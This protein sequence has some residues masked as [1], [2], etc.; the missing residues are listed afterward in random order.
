MIYLAWSGVNS[1][2][3]PELNSDRNL[4]TQQFLQTNLQRLERELEIVKKDKNEVTVQSLLQRSSEVITVQTIVVNEKLPAEM[5]ATKNH[6]KALNAVKQYPYLSPDQITTLRN[7]LDTVGKEIQNLIE[8]KV[9]RDLSL[10][11]Q[12]YAR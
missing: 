11:Y 7:K 4:V 3:P 9:R 1:N 6:I 5:H 8:L 10:I 12:L 2:V